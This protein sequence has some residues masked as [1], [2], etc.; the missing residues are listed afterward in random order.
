MLVVPRGWRCILVILCVDAC[1]LWRTSATH[2]DVYVAVWP[3]R[4]AAAGDPKKWATWWVMTGADDRARLCRMDQAADLNGQIE[5]LEINCNVVMTG[6]Q[7][8]VFECFLT[9]DGKGMHV[10]NDSPDSKCWTCEDMD[11]LDPNDNVT[12]VPRSGRAFLR[13]M[14]RTKRVGDYAHGAARLCNTI[15]QRL[16]SYLCVPMHG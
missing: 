6:G 11:S 4:P 3:G 12:A 5:Y 10:C 14:P 9:G 7:T 1:P 8:M 16:G 15:A 2:A 13:G